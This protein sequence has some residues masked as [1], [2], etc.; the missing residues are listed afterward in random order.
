MLQ[1]TNGETGTRLV[2][3]VVRADRLY[4]I[5]A[6]VSG[7]PDL[8][9]EWNRSA[10]IRS[11]EAPGLGRIDNEYLGVRTGDHVAGGM[12][13]AAG[14]RSAAPASTPPGAIT[15]VDLA[16]TLSSALGVPMNGSDGVVNERLCSVL[17]CP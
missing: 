12:V 8:F 7:L 14:R 9:I 15:V 6:E 3:R 4:G 10:P 2:R 16:P 11:V 5:D 13:V 17:A 1:W